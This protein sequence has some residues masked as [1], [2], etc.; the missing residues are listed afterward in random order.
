MT[1]EE[2]IE[3]LKY[4]ISGECCDNTM[5]YVE[6]IETAIEAMQRLIGLER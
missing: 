6:E 1:Y 2:A 4:L 3:G 5:D